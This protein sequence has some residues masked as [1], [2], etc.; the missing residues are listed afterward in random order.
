MANFPVLKTGA[1]AQYPITRELR[2]KNQSLRFVDGSLQRY[3]DS[4]GVR[5]R[6]VV[7]LDLLDEGE[8]AAVEEF[9]AGQQ[10]AYAEFTFADP[11]DGAEYAHCRLESDDA[12]LVSSGEMRGSA[13]LTVVRG[14]A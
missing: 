5:Q 14:V 9:F 3:R 7:R 13:T 1:V 4:A 12:V 8:L 2:L 6:W 11:W 10:G